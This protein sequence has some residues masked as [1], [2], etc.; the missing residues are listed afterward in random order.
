VC[1]Y[2]YKKQ[3]TKL[4]G[5]GKPA[6]HNEIENETIEPTIPLLADAAGSSLVDVLCDFTFAQLDTTMGLL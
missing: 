5:N 6:A 1:S 2:L 3:S 4:A